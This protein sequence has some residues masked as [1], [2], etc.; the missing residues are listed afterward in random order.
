MPAIV[1]L[2]TGMLSTLWLR[3]AGVCLDVLQHC[4]HLPVL[5]VCMGHQVRGRGATSLEQPTLCIP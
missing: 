5:G 3:L 4:T 2:A 1:E